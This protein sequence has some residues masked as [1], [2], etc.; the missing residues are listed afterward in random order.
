MSRPVVSPCTL[1]DLM[2]HEALGLRRATGT[3]GFDERQV[4]SVQI[5]SDRFDEARLG[6]GDLIVL[7]AGWSDSPDAFEQLADVFA[8]AEVA[9]VAYPETLAEATQLDIRQALARR[10]VPAM[11]IPR[12]TRFADIIDTVSRAHA[13]PDTA[14]FQRMLSMQ[15]SLV[16]SMSGNDPAASLVRRLATLTDGIGG[17]TDDAGAVESATG[18]LPFV[19]FRQEIGGFEAPIIDLEVAGWCGLA[20][21]LHSLPER[22]RRWLIVANRREDF[23]NAYTRTAAAVTA[24]LIEASKRIDTLAMNQDRAVRSSILRRALDLQPNENADE[25]NEQAAALGLSFVQE[26]RVLSVVQPIASKQHRLPT[27]DLFEET[28]TTHDATV[29]TREQHN[30]YTVLIQANTD[31]RDRTI[32]TM[33]SMHPGLFVGTGRAIEQIGE[34][35]TSHQDAVL[36]VQ[37]ALRSHTRRSTTYDELDFSIRLLAD[38]GQASMAAWR[39]RILG[40]FRDKPLLLEAITAYFAHEF[41]VMAAAKD[42]KI[43]HNS[44][45]YR[46][47]KVEEIL[48]ASVRSPSMITALHLAMT[49]EAA[50]DEL[51]AERSGPLRPSTEQHARVAD[52][53]VGDAPVGAPVFGEPDSFGAARV[54]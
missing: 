47:S 20:V 40:P 14:R 10:D 25:L 48:G 51:T 30:G 18:V 43:H 52:A 41:D 32:K 38:I 17:I 27:A 39:E 42:L 22:P 2:T 23:A 54:D 3:N 44:M 49:A 11:V 7:I 8:D 45:R 6:A 36:A 46:L 5:F 12:T 1:G 37:H 4:N 28:L 21:R 35:P 26:V 13:N 19:L 15:Q 34:V 50:G 29:F 33:L 24:S 9:G 31:Q 53:V 16:A